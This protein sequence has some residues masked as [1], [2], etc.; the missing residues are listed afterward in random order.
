MIRSIQESSSSAPYLV[1]VSKLSKKEHGAV[2]CYPGTDLR[3]FGERVKQLKKLEVTNLVLEGE[4]KIGKHGVLG[5]GCVSVV[6]RA[7]K[8][9]DPNI[10]ALKI[11]RT[12]AN[13]PSMKKD[14]DLQKLANSFSVGPKVVSA[15]NDLFLMEYVDAIKIGK[16]FAK[17]RTRTSKRYVRKLV[18]KI[19]HQCF[20]LDMHSL[21]HGELSNPSKHI[22]I[23]KQAEPEVVIIDYESASTERRTSNLTSVAQFLFLNGT[24]IRRILGIKESENITRNSRLVKLLRGYKEDRSQESFEKILSYVRC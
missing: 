15:T 13:R 10:Y 12:D 20:L 18:R 1:R 22:L 4:S 9:N 2:L 19:L 17:L 16:W 24:K 23:R 8:K 11:R 21:D 6:V 7:R 5:K 14:Y 3:T